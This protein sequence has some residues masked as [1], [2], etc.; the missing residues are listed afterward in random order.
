LRS[1]PYILLAFSLLLIISWATVYARDNSVFVARGS[2]SVTSERDSWLGLWLLEGYVNMSLFVPQC[3][4]LSLIVYSKGG[5]QTIYRLDV[6]ALE[7]PLREVYVFKTPHPGY[8]NVE[9][10][11]RQ[12][13]GCEAP[14]VNGAL[15]VYQHAQPETITRMALLIPAV[16]SLITALTLIVIQQ[17][18]IKTKPPQL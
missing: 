13:E 6:E 8:Y 18:R 5:G 16:I 1:T 3:H 4:R 14:R 10:K 2:M 12:I 11:L 17:F 15:N 7:K 9:V